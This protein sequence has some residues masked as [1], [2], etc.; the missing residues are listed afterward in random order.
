MLNIKAACAFASLF[1]LSAC[2]AESEELINSSA[3][4][5]NN[6]GKTDQAIEDLR[7]FLKENFNN[8]SYGDGERAA[9]AKRIDVPLGKND[10]NE[11]DSGSYNGYCCYCCWK[12]SQ[13]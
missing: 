2:A 6:Y 13:M 10:K 3:Q 7:K 11:R 12:M 4:A 8:R 5:R 1:V 9:M